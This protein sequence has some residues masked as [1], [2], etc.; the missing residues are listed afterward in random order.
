MSRKENV[1]DLIELVIRVG[2]I[3]FNYCI[4]AT[5]LDYIPFEL[6]VMSVIVLCITDW[7]L[8]TNTL[9]KRRK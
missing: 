1:C 8:A 9:L 2:L 5:A 3:V 7:I 4:Y 6:G